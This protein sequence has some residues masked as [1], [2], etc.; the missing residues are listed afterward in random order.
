MA[1]NIIEQGK[2]EENLSNTKDAKLRCKKCNGTEVNSDSVLYRHLWAFVLGTFLI[3][4]GIGWII[5]AIPVAR[6][7]PG[8]TNVFGPLIITCI[9]GFSLLAYGLRQVPK[10]VYTCKSCGN[11]WRR[12]TK[13]GPEKE[14]YNR[15]VDWQIFR[16]FHNNLDIRK[17]A[18]KWL[19]EQKSVSAVESL[20]K[21][22]GERQRLLFQLRIDTISALKNIGDERA[23][24]PLIDT[25]RDT[26]WGYVDVRVAAIKALSTFD[27]DKI[28]EALD[29]ASHDKKT[30]VSEAA[31]ESLKIMNN[32]N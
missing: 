26:G 8:N 2:E 22:L 5:W 31:I 19:G 3:I 25:A 17:E 18:A 14:D 24:Q 6:T 23:I 10:Y 1:E 4:L 13:E 28:R 16:L 27:N 9:P 20:I 15:F 7:I 12:S 21:C 30:V 29:M 11:I 32:K